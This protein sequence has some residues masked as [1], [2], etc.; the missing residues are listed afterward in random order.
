M[1]NDFISRSKL[2]VEALIIFIKKR[3]ESLK[4]C[5]NYKE[6]N[7]IV[8]KNKYFIS[9]ITNILNKFRKAKVFIKLNFRKVYNLLR[10]KKKNEWKIVFRMRY[11]TFE[12]NVFFFEFS[13][14]EVSFQSYIDR[15]LTKF[16]NKFCICYLNDIFI[17]S[18]NKKKLEKH[19]Q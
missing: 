14:E 15:A 12:Y 5:V 2:S 9:L 16:L 19:V 7:A 17:Y 8:V 1:K 11:E 10:I 6:L 4:L 13:N 18:E 3:N